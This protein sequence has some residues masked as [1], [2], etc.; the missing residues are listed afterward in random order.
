VDEDD[1]DTPGLFAASN[2]A[3]GPLPDDSGSDLANLS[4]TFQ[5]AV[6]TVPTVDDPPPSSNFQVSLPIESVPTATMEDD[7]TDPFSSLNLQPLLTDAGSIGSGLISAFVT[8][9]Q[10]ATTAEGQSLANAEIS[11]LTTSNLFSYLL[12]GLVIFLVFQFLERK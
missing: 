8:N 1:L 3:A 5:P 12:I 9:P 6:L 10:N 2:D 7:A 4:P 11:N